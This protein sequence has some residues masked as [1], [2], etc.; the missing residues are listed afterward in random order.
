MRPSYYLLRRNQIILFQRHNQSLQKLKNLDFFPVMKGALHLKAGE[1]YLLSNYDMAIYHLEK[2]LE[3]FHLYQDKSRYKQALHDI[4]F[5][6]ISHWRDIDKID[7]KQLHPAEQALFHIELG[8]YDK[9]II[10]LDDLERKNG[11]LTALQWGRSLNIVYKRHR[12]YGVFCT[13]YKNFL[14]TS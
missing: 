13:F 4:H 6:R 12:L 14:N 8:Q 3:I 5:L 7:F 2:S 9:A 1:S 11:K 10:L